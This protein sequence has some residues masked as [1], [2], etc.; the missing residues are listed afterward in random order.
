[1]FQFGQVYEQ[2]PLR[3]E[4]G[5]LLYGV[6]GTGKTLLACALAG[7]AGLNFISIKVSFLNLF[8]KMLIRFVV[9]T[10]ITIRNTPANN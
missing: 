10:Q 9:I 7:E 2:C 1:M 4:S 5:V 8:V 6:P 3:S